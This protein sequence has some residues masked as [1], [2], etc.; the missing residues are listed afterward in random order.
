MW[1]EQLATPGV[2]E[3]VT[4]VIPTRR[5]TEPEEV[6]DVVAFLASDASRSITGETLCADGGIHATVNLYPTV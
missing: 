4:A 5:L 1:R 2:P 6:A 3:A